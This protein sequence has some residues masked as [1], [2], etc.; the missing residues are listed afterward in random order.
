M[1]LASFLPQKMRRLEGEKHH[2]GLQPEGSMPVPEPLR[3][4][5]L[6][7]LHLLQN[8]SPAPCR[9]LPAALCCRTCAWFPSA[10]V[11]L[12]PV[13]VS[14]LDFPWLGQPYRPPGSPPPPVLPW[15][16]QPFQ[17][18]LNG[19]PASVMLPLTSWL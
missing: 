6:V 19:Y 13:L 17:K 9:C 11:V 8:S 10:G 14:S 12:S 16:W 2:G 7:R 18:A 4:C 1:S 3:L 15:L 5:G